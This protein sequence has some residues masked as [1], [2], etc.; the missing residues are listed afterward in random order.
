MRGGLAAAWLA[1][2]AMGQERPP[3]EPLVRVTTRL[4]EVDVVVR[5]ASGPVMG[6]TAD[7][8]TVLDKGKPQKIAVFA[9]RTPGSRSAPAHPLPQGTVSNRVNARG[10]EVAG[11]TVI[12]ID[13][14]NTD[15]EDQ[16]ELRRQLLRYLR[17][18][19]DS[20][21]VAVYSLY[22]TLR[23]VQDFTH[24][25]DRLRRAVTG[26]VAESSVDL[27]TEDLTGDLP[28]TGDA[29]SDGMMQAVAA[30]FRDRA[31]RNRVDV[32]A[33]AL[34]S[35]AR[36]LAGL[37]GRKK[38]IWASSAFPAA[39][40]EQ[41]S[42]LG[43]TQIEQFNFADQID[44]AARALNQANVAV[45]PIDP[46][47]PIRGGFTAPGID[48][49]NLFANK[50]G[51]QAQYVLSDL[52]AAIHRAAHDDDVT[53]VLGFYPEYVKLDGSYHPLDV[54]VARRGV[55]VRHRQGYFASNS[56]PPDSKQRKASLN[57]AFLDPLESTAIGLTGSATPVAGKSGTHL[58]ELLLNLNELHL[59]P[60]KGRWV[61]LIAIA[62]QF[63]VKK[64]PNGTLEEIKITLTEERLKEALRDG[65][66]MKRE[67]SAGGLVGNLRIVL[68]D[69]IT[70]QAGSV[71][72]AIGK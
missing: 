58:L 67:F 64:P 68:Q 47:N 23:V 63:P 40:M 55:E 39:Y 26:S 28:R 8:F 10:E 18:L 59:E 33:Y 41:R 69:R 71:T 1:A 9:V 70:G 13:R 44:K 11:L 57:E 52:A 61:A 34:E 20:E 53:Y 43:R 45:Y 32:T 22:K 38:L 4:V 42:R 7:D 21:R 54:K 12:L 19:G 56:R 15:P 66:S 14:I 36:H 29:I 27:M 25:P 2:L 48:T 62:T 16:I 46:R 37:P 3:D 60:E 50:T 65:Y 17:E 72:V 51:G 24:D 35:I 31:I 30:E 6:L 5:S 49:M